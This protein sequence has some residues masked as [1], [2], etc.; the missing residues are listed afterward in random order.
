MK[1]T[2]LEQT[3]ASSQF[4]N[5]GL[6][7]FSPT[8]RGQGRPDA[9]RRYDPT[10]Q[11]DLPPEPQPPPPQ[12]LGGC[13]HLRN[14]K[15]ASC[16]SKICCWQLPEFSRSHSSSEPPQSEWG[17]TR[18]KGDFCFWKRRSCEL[19]EPSRGCFQ[20]ASLFVWLIW[21][22]HRLSGIFPDRWVHET[23]WQKHITS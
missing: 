1:L 20:T 17:C 8:Q 12:G 10:F 7:I 4:L 22:C 23:L 14:P 21:T 16:I 15:Q 2:G 5:C 18:T 3:S 6:T 11:P 9:W 19:C 13:F